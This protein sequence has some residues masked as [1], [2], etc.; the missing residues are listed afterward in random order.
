MRN[1]TN[2]SRS[3]QPQAENFAWRTTALAAA[4]KVVSAQ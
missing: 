3:R 2:S 1:Q 4:P